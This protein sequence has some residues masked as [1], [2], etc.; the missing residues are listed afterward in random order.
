[1][2]GADDATI[3]AIARDY[4]SAPVD[5]QT[6]ALL[7]FAHKLSREPWKITHRDWDTLLA[8]GWSEA[9]CIEAVHIVGLFE[10]FNRVADGFGMESHGREHPLLLEGLHTNSHRDDADE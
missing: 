2:Q 3:Q 7:A 8:T 5:E 1:M 6:R 10:Y 9:Q 4:R